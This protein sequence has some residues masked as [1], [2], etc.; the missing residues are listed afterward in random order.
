[1]TLVARVISYLLY[2]SWYRQTI[3]KSERLLIQKAKWVF[4]NKISSKKTIQTD[5]SIIKKGY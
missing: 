3:Y 5:C 1:M 2:I 4:E